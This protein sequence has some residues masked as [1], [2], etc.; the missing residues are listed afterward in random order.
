MTET[1]DL[2]MDAAESAMRQRGYHAVSFREL[3]DDVGIKSAS[4]HYYF[5]QK[6]DLGLALVR[7]YSAQFFADL[8]VRSARAV[9]PAD[10]I[11]AFCDTY[12]QALIQ[13]DK[14]CLCGMLGAETCGLPLELSTAVAEFFDANIDWVS[15]ALPKGTKSSVRRAKAE[16]IVATLQ[17]ALM[18][19]TS[20]RNHKVFDRA[21]KA[22]TLDMAL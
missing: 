1:V 4:V 10:L 2:L 22:M 19:A 15:K 13:A 5:P 17:G 6:E 14:I 12:R 20:L 8:E 16:Q 11:A 21:A 9:T 18:L 7:R 3:A